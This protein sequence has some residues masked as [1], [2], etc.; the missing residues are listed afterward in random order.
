[1]KPKKTEIKVC[2]VT[3]K[4]KNS[5]E[6][7]S[8][9]K[10]GRTSL[11]NTIKE[12]L[13]LY[14]ANYRN[15]TKIEYDPNNKMTGKRHR[16]EIKLNPD[17]Y[18]YL[19]Q[20]ATIHETTSNQM[21]LAQVRYLMNRYPVLSDAELKTV[22]LSNI[23]LQQIGRNLNQIAK[24]LNSMNGASITTQYIQALQNEINQHT[25]SVGELISASKK[26]YEEV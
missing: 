1:M 4:M 10:F 20:M 7:I 14:I 11:S 9:R 12:I 18:A 3:E 26:R 8:Y 24:Q 21:L 23:R 5:L 19:R 17:E 22:R 2:G 6:E 25:Q 13:R 16:M 15:P